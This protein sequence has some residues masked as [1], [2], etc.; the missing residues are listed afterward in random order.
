MPTATP[1][2]STTGSVSAGTAAQPP[3]GVAT[4]SA[5]SIDRTE[6][7]D[8]ARPGE[9]GDAVPEHDVEREEG[10]VREREGDAE[11]LPGEHDVCEQ[12]DAEDCER[13][14]GAVPPGARPERREHDHGQE[15]DRGDRAERQPVDREVEA[16]VH[17]AEHGAPRDD[18]AAL[19]AAERRPTPA[20]DVARARRRRRRP[21]SAARRRRAAP[22]G[23][24]AAP[25]TPARGS[26][27]PRCRRS[28]R[29]AGVP[30]IACR[31]DPRLRGH[32]TPYNRRR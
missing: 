11:R 24:R 5:T 6:R 17:D 22:G 3:I 14:R 21:R 8:S 26:G 9:P 7:I 30:G 2:A 12:V 20:T 23:R 31:Y 10:G 28:T 4:R 32:S 25:R 16:A 18:R 15:L 1:A 13:Q 27:R 19:G 29:A